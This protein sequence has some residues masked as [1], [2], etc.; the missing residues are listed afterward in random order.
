MCVLQI[1]K[2]NYRKDEWIT[3][4]NSIG[5]IEPEDLK[6]YPLIYYYFITKEKIKRNMDM[7]YIKT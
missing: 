6:T 2:P 1:K 4:G 7:P 5:K 3:Q